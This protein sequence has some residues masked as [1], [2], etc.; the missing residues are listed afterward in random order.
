MSR[1]IIRK[2]IGLT[3]IASSIVI[4]VLKLSNISQARDSI[5]AW[6]LP[7]DS[8]LIFIAVLI[9]ELVMLVSRFTLGYFIYQSNNIKPWVLYPL[10]VLTIISGLTGVALVFTFLVLRK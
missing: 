3:L 7:E 2:G 4:L 10:A 1:L 8:A 9:F 6:A 5:N